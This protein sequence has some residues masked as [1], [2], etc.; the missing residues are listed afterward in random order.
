M[1]RVVSTSS[2]RPG[3]RCL[4]VFARTPDP[5]IQRAPRSSAKSWFPTWATSPRA[6]CRSSIPGRPGDPIKDIP[7]RRYLRAGAFEPEAPTGVDPLLELQA[8][9]AGA[10]A[11]LDPLA[12][13]RRPGLHR[14]QSSGHRGRR[15]RRLLRAVDQRQRRRAGDRSTTRS[16]ARSP[17]GR[18]PWTVWPPAAPVPRAS[19]TR[20]S[21]TIAPP[22]AGCS[23]SSPRAATTSASTSRPATTR[24]APTAATT[25]IAPGFPDYPKYGVWPDAYYVT[26]NESSP[27][28]YALDRENMAACGTARAAQRFTVADLSGFGFQ[29][30]TPADLDGVDDP[31]PGAPGIVMRHRDTEAHGPAGVADDR[32]AR[33][34]GFRCRLDHA[35]E[36]DAHRAARDRRRRIR[37][38][39][40]RPDRRSSA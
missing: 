8:A 40:V 25:S 24:P 39:A 1:K 11:S 31:P 22:T 9:F 15:R 14:R 13:P 21:S 32:P 17:P 34:L 37:L 10:P 26:T 7:R 27:A 16:P 28:V 23:R 38:D 6:I 12:Q 20:S 30:L 18:S 4:P 2:P 36:L 33:A 29:A 5:D 3:V 35:G 19:A